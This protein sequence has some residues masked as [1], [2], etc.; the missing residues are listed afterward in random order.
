MKHELH[1]IPSPGAE[2][3]AYGEW[4][5]ESSSG[6]LRQMT[7]LQNHTLRRAR[8]LAGLARAGR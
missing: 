7:V 4:L 2:S 8:P 1:H 5:C 6:T 3:A